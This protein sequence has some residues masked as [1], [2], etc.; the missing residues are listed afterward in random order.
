MSQTLTQ[1]RWKVSDG[2]KSGRMLTVTASSH[3]FGSPFA[4]VET[5]AA[6]YGVYDLVVTLIFVHRFLSLKINDIQLTFEVTS[7]NLQGISLRGSKGRALDAFRHFDSLED[8]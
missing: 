8:F 7:G 5:A 2:V 4:D 6:V 1:P 3:E